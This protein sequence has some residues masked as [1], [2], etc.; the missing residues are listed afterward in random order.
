MQR[1][2]L[3][4][5]ILWLVAIVLFLGVGGALL[6]DSSVVAV[7]HVQIEGATGQD[8]E[9]LRAALTSAA[10]DM[11]TLHVR[12]G[13]L[14][15]VAEPYPTVASISVSAK[16]P[17]TLRIKVKSRTPVAA[18]VAGGTRQAVAADGVILRGVK[19]G[20]VP[21]VHMDGLPTGG[22][23]KGGRALRAIRILGAAPEPL[24]PKI[25]ELTFTSDG[26]VVKLD[27]GPDLRFG[28]AS[29]PHA[30]WLA[31]ARVLADPSS[32][33]ATY[34]DVALPERAAAGGLENPSTQHDPRLGN[35]AV[36]PGA[37]VTTPAPAV[38]PAPAAPTATT[39]ISQ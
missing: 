31:A 3:L 24:R 18:I 5:R 4:R 1:R 19:P 27:E 17:N 15:T 32:K 30:K 9:H 22:R 39:T 25:S 34:I 37:A 36:I 20:A 8:A 26:I 10:R 6:R 2:Y 12:E 23:V 14:K 11:T 13:E 7:K 28:D 33:G 21:I 38:A 35:D 29:R 16:L